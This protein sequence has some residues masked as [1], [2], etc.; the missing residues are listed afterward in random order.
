MTQDEVIRIARDVWG[1]A[2]ALLQ[3]A[4]I[5]RFAALISAHEREQCAK[6]CDEIANE[7]VT[8]ACDSEAH[9]AGGC[10]TAIRARGES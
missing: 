2:A 10:S 8:L 6:V 1:A 9:G 7:L 5:E 4:D 3:F